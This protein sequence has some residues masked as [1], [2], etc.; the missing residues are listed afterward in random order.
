VLDNAAG[1]VKF[2]TKVGDKEPTPSFDLSELAGH[3][4]PKHEDHQT[5]HGYKR[6]PKE[7]AADG[8]NPTFR[9]KLLVRFNYLGI[10]VA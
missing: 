1:K 9:I 2:S 6:H 8:P 5:A 7:K 4:Q 10:F 3:D